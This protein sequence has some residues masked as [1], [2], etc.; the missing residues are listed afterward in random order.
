[1]LDNISKF[2]KKHI[3]KII[4]L[5][6]S[7][8]VIWVYASSSTRDFTTT[9][10]YTYSGATDF[11][12]TWSIASLNQNT[13]VHTWVVSSW[14]SYNWAYDVV[15][16]GNYAYM[17]S[18][19]WDRVNVIDIR[20]PSNPILTW[21]II[22]NWWTIRLD[23][24]AWIIKEWNLLYVTANVSDAVQVIDVTNPRIPVATWSIVDGTN[25]NWAR[26]IAKSWNYLFITSDVRDTLSVINVTN[27]RLPSRSYTL[28]DTTNFN[29]ARDI[30]I[31]WTYAYVTAYDWNRFSVVNISTP[32]LPVFSTGILDATFLSQ[33]WRLEISWNYAYVSA[34]NNASVRVINITNPLAPVAVTSISWWS[35]SIT[36]PMDLVADWNRLYISSFWLDAVNIADITDPTAPTY[37][38]K[39]IHNAAN[40]LLDWAYW[41]FKVWDL[42]YT[43]VYNSDA[44]EI[45]RLSYPSNSPFLQ[46]TTAFNYGVS[47]NLLTFSETLW[48]WNEWTITYQISKDNWTTWYYLNWTTWTTTTW[49]VANSTSATLIN[50]YLSTFN[51]LAWWT[52]IF[53]YKAFFTSNWV[54]KVELDNLSVTASDP[55]SPGWVST[56]MSIWLKADKWTNSTTDWASITSWAD[57]SG[58][59]YD[60]TTWVAPSYINNDTNNLNYNPLISFDWSTYLENLNNWANSISYYMVI[61]PDNLVDWTLPWQAPFWID[62]ES[63]IISSWTC[64]L[65]LGWTILWAFTAAMNDEVVTHALWSSTSRRSAQIWAYSYSS[66]SPMILNS[67]QNSLWNWT[68]IYEKWV[69]IDNFTANTYQSV[70]TADYR[71]WRSLDPVN[72]YPY[73]WKVAE[74]IDYTSRLS[75][76]DRQKIESYLSLKYGITLNAWTQNYFASDWTT[77]MWNT[78]GA[79]TYIN[80]IFWIWRDDISWLGQVKSKSTNTD[81][82]I[83]LEAI[84]EWTNMS[85]SFV[86]IANKEFFTVS[87]NNLAN[88]WIQSWA[89]SW[90][91]IL[92]RTWKVQETWDVGTVLFDFNVANSNFDVPILSTW[93]LYYFI[94]DSN[95]NSSLSDETPMSM[96]NISW[97]IWRISW[98]NLSNWMIFTLWSLT[99]TNN[100]PTNITL[101]NNA[102]NENVA[103]WSTIWTFTTTDADLWDTHTYSLVTWAWDTDNITFT[104]TWTTLK[105]NESPDYEIKSSYSIR[106]QTDD[107][108][109]WQYQKI[110]TININ[111]IWETIS[112]II[113]FETPW[114]YTVTSWNWTRLTTNP[115]ENA[116]SIISNNWW[117]PN[118]Q[119][120][121]EVTNTLTQTWTISFFYNVSSQAWADYLRFYIDNIEQQNWSWTVPWTN[122]T[123]NNL[124]LWYH[125]YK[126]CYIKDWN[127]NTWNDNANIDY[128]TFQFSAVDNFSPTIS[129][130]N[131]ASWYLLPWWNHTLIIDY[132]DWESGINTTSDIITLN[133]WNWTAWGS[134]ISATGLNLAWKTVWSTQATYPTNNLIFWKYSYL[135]QISDNNANSSSTWAVFYIDE[136]EIIISTWSYDLWNI[137]W[138]WLNFSANEITATIKTV[139][140]S[141]QVE[142]SKDTDF[143][144]SSGSIIID[145]DWSAG[146]WYDKNPYTLVN[147]NINNNP[148]VWTWATN[149]NINWDKNI[150]TF[151]IKIWTLISEEQEAGIYNMSLS[152]RAIFG[153]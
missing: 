75:D 58:N 152:F 124:T 125:S 23:W 77:Y 97:N 122:Y 27:P 22:N 43:A 6:L 2:T 120:C 96:S 118:T 65:P 4:F 32:T 83:T 136:P 104:I 103:S 119:S 40:P 135:F 16:D 61:I 69:K 56:N 35:Y 37:V 15:V 105:I 94:Y 145:W 116:Y 44:L 98:V 68:D 147:K 127:T 91:D 54:Q 89:P 126:W 153:Y 8:C 108:N 51:A 113:D 92:S 88:T 133:K 25:L 143:L 131:F 62:C 46:P 102:I 86:D 30:K 129:S 60:A 47:Q 99:S 1:M 140:A 14:T 29:W 31:V 81:W 149:I 84:W 49:W 38:W 12:V 112:T 132:N 138:S 19:L 63:W 141:Y 70:S 150:Y 144:N 110:F 79:G 151:P 10:D 36:N 50:S 78:G 82:I 41:L 20:N 28:R 93:S 3:K 106:V 39:V 139:W 85:N 67:N 134:D 72:I 76:A 117:L 9:T 137:T 80:D 48:A 95:S 18:F 24:A 142:M 45:L 7:F 123:K 101:S 115:Y 26:W 55:A 87:N 52:W 74:I 42:I 13:L 114:K 17:T 59:W 57:Q 90:Y 109:W 5:G 121:F 64:W 33:A 73:Y 53:T 148:I 66:G 146:V 107:G 111:N 100:I 71:I 128:I 21:S 34:Y 130:I 11:T